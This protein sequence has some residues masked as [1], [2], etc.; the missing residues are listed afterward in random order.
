VGATD[1]E[2]DGISRRLL[3][4]IDEL[5]SIEGRKRL[6]ARSTNEFHELADRA[7][8]VAHEVFKSAERERRDG[9]DDSP[10][11]QERAEQHP[12]DWSDE[13]LA[14]RSS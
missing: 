12:G 13:Q 11:P 3:N 7:A 6:T 4:G 10:D 9:D 14:G 5:R 8:D 2:L 1:A